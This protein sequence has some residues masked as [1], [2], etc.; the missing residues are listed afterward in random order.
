MNEQF[1][2][3]VSRGDFLYQLF[4]MLGFLAAYVILIY[5]GYRRQ[6]P[7]VRWIILLACIRFFVVIG[8]K[9][10]SFSPEDWISMFKNQILFQNTEKTMFGGLISG[11]AGYYLA[12]YLLKF[13]YNVWDTVAVA[14]P[15]AVSIQTIGCFFYGCCF[16]SPSTLPWAVKYPVMTLAHYHQFESGILTYHDLYSIPV[17]PVQLYQCLGGILVTILVIR[18]RKY[19][20]AKG[21]LLLSSA[22]FFSLIRMTIEFFRDPLSNKTGGEM[23]WALK[24]V[25][26]Q[27]LVFAVLMVLLLIR[28]ERTFKPVSNLA[29]GNDEPRL[30]TQIVFLFSLIFVLLVLRNWFT[31]PEIVALNIALIPAVIFL[32]IEIYK[33]NTFSRYRWVYVCSLILPLF[34]MSQTFPQTQIDSTFNKNYTTYHTI[35][36]G[37][38][39]GS[40]T[41]DRMNYTGRGCDMISNHEYFRQ[42]YLVGGAGYSYTKEDPDRQVITRYG[43]NIMFGNYSQV[44]QTDNAEHKTFL[45]G[46]N[47]YIKYD[48]K[49]IGIGG[50]LHL[51]N[52]EYT[53]GDLRK[54][55]SANPPIPTRGSFKTI[56]MPQLDLRVGV[57]RFFFGD[58]HLA[59][60]FPVSAP[61]LAFQAGIGSGFGLEN[62]FNMRAGL[63]FLDHSAFYVTGYF[64]IENRLVIEPLF[65]WTSKSMNDS[66]S[67]KLPENQFS[68]GISYRFGYK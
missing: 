64:P 8:T 19:W 46:V 31:F 15:V 14:F 2:V 32:G 68:I 55:F 13:R 37:F 48:T 58:F 21:S 45:F 61:G 47:P 53:T 56:L 29:K 22:I 25:Q 28:R 26:W 34:L 20:K 67:V 50:G 24:V 23:L 38:A 5:E 27:Y 65:L 4:Y 30:K 59:D 6:F 62:G 7:L 17:H 49:W 40:Y 36:G 9:V 66:Y 10:F 3:D 11:V 44:R 54:E 33:A 18:L 12:R 52:L 1:I 42:K 51:G 43:A 63:S 35:G 41:D 60:H 57:S 16:G 39:K